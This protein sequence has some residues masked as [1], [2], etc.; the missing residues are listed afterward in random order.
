VLENILFNFRMPVELK[1]AFEKSCARR[2]VAMTSQLNILISE[3][4]SAEK[5]NRQ[6]IERDQD[7]PLC[8]FTTYKEMEE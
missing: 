6:T 4:I 3:F 1:D 2:N 5:K 8:F 7:E